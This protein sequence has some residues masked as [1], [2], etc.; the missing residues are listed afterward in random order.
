MQVANY[1]ACNIYDQ[2]LEIKKTEWVFRH[3]VKPLVNILLFCVSLKNQVSLYACYKT[4]S[5]QFLLKIYHK[6]S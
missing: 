6:Q 2:T 4:K 3:G 5:I 1:I